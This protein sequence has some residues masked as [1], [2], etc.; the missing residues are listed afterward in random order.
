M[1]FFLNHNKIKLK[2]KSVT[3]VGSDVRFTSLI[4]VDFLHTLIK[5]S[6]P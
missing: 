3:C 2:H 1:V 4:K 5:L 6:M